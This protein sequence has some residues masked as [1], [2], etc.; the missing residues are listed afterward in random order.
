MDVIL[1]LTE[2]VIIGMKLKL[3]NLEDFSLKHLKELPVEMMPNPV[4]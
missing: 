1:K 3:F 2:S 4:F